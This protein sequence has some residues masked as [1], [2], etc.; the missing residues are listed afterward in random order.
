VN[1]LYRGESVRPRLH[2]FIGFSLQSTHTCNSLFN[3]KAAFLGSRSE[4]ENLL[5]VDLKKMIADSVIS[6]PV[7][8][9]WSCPSLVTQMMHVKSL[10]F[11]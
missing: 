3:E 2:L 9:A 7:L 10:L 1:A 5:S 6:V 8:V 4:S 11:N